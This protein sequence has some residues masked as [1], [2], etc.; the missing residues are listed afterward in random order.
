MFPGSGWL[1]VLVD[2]AS[3]MVLVT[4]DEV[5]LVLARPLLACQGRQAYEPGCAHFWFL[6][7]LIF[8]DKREASAGCRT[9]QAQR[10]NERGMDGSRSQHSCSQT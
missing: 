9:T 1:V 7:P 8:L 6:G 5:V 2:R 3:Q 4:V 10:R